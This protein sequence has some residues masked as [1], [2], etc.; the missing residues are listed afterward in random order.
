VI[1]S[2]SNVSLRAKSVSKRKPHMHTYALH[3]QGRV[4]RDDVAAFLAAFEVILES[5]S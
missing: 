1:D 3:E 4:P 2:A 5:M